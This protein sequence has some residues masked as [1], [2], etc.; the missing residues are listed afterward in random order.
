MIKIKKRISFYIK[1]FLLAVLIL[2]LAEQYAY[3]NYPAIRSE[4]YS[5]DPVLFW[6]IARCLPGER[7]N[8][9]GICNTYHMRENDD[10]VS[11]PSVMMLGDSCTY[12]VFVLPSKTIPGRLEEILRKDS[13]VPFRVYNAGCPGYSSQQSYYFLKRLAPVYKPDIII[14]ADYYGDIGY[15]YIKDIDRLPPEPLLTMKVLLWKSNVYRVLRAWYQTKFSYSYNSSSDKKTPKVMRV[16]PDEYYANVTKIKELGRKFNSCLTVITYYPKNGNNYIDDIYVPSMKKLQDDHTVFVD[17]REIWNSKR[18]TKPDYFLDDMHF[19][20]KG[21][22]IVAGDLAEIIEGREEF[23]ELC[24][25]FEH[26]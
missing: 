19:S 10:E 16:M 15:D 14:V 5:E 6:K 20:E 7:V 2:L 26:Q 11:H 3:F 1:S 23:K 24:R 8:P 18:Q 21:C 22:E 13:G 25:R 4:H 17:L 12:G 9:Y